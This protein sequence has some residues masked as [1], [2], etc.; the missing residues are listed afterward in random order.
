MLADFDPLSAAKARQVSGQAARDQ[1]QRGN[2]SGRR[3]AATGLAGR[4]ASAYDEAKLKTFLKRLSKRKE[5]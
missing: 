2:N 4:G 5:S 1:A 3:D